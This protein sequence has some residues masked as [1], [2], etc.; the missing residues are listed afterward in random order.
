MACHIG[1]TD[2][3]KKTSTDRFTLI[4]NASRSAKFASADPSGQDSR[5]RGPSHAEHR[6]VHSQSRNDLILTGYMSDEVLAM[7]YNLCK[8]FV[9]PSYNEV[10]G[11]P[12]SE[13]M[14]W[15]TAV[16]AGNASSIPEIVER[17]DALIDPFSEVATTS[18][19]T[20]ALENDEFCEQL[21]RH[22]IHN[23]VIF[24]RDKC[25]NSRIAALEDV[26]ADRHQSLKTALWPHRRPKLAYISP[27][28]PER[29][30][31]SDYSTELL[32]ELARHYD[33]EVINAQPEVSDPWIRA[34]LPIRSVEYFA[35]N[36]DNFERVL[37]HFGNSAF[38]HYMFDLL[39]RFPGVVVLHDFFLGDAYEYLEHISP[40]SWTRELSNSH[41]YKAL[42][43]RFAK[44]DV[45]EVIFK[46]PCNF[47]VL[48]MAVGVIVHSNY[49]V[50]LANQWYGDSIARHFV[51]IP[52]L[53]DLAK[54]VDRDEARR[55]LGVH[56]DDFMVCSFG[57]LGPI[58]QNHRLLE[59]FLKS[60][61]SKDPGC[62]LIFIGENDAGEYGRE[63]LKTVSQSGLKER[64]LVTGWV[65]ADAFRNYLAAA[66][67]AVQLRTISRGES[68][69]AVLDCMSHALATIVN[70]NGSLAELPSDAVWKLSD[71]F[72]NDELIWALETLWRDPGRRLALGSR[73]REVIMT[74][75]SSSRCADMYEKA[76]EAFYDG[77]KSCRA[78]LIDDLARSDNLFTEEGSITALADSI[79]QCRSSRRSAPQILIDIS[80]LV[81]I[82]IKTGIQRVTRSILR[83][84][85]LNQP[86]GYRIEPVYVSPD[87]NG[88][89]YAREFCLHFLN[90]PAG[91][92]IDEPIDANLGDIFL[93]LDLHHEAIVS[94]ANY[95]ESLRNAGVRIFFI[96]Y[97]ILPIQIPDA[98]PLGTDDIHKRWLSSICR[99]S[100]GVMCIS[101]TVADDVAEWLN[102][103]GQ[104]RLRPL[105]IGWFHIGADI[106]NS[107][108]TQGLPDDA[109]QIL[110][111]LSARPSF[112]MVGTVEPRKG[113]LQAIAAFEQLWNNG[114]DA[115]LVIVGKEG[116]KDLPNDLRRTI[117]EIVNRLRHHPELDCRLF[118]LEGISDEYLEKIYIVSTCLIAA[119]EGEGFGLPLIEAAQHKLPI[120]ARDIPVFRE[121]AG[122]HAFYFSGKEPADLADSIRG[123]LAL[124]RSGKHPRSYGMAWL[125]WNE[126]AE[127]LL[128][129]ILNNRWYTEW[130]WNDDKKE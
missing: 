40:G 45:R 121:V 21:S 73:A 88:Y 47:S 61:M 9:F 123:W 18:K 127:R 120:I 81:Q 69:K 106:E 119:S 1:G 83:E 75:N 30:G 34:H 109:S 67:I 104:K 49:S 98:F 100:D 48:E 44:K 115:N 54:M 5:H 93:G 25:V 108:P 35:K 126:S 90:C 57:I 50:T 2:I 36:A 94:Q 82:D 24:S 113:Y 130:K 97:N 86:A 17:E 79:T 3:Q 60:E 68:S 22:S 46:Y 116:W 14:A 95:L 62:K 91:G 129:I 114:V 8:L 20:E 59:A 16:I 72:K 85:L 52:M 70:S 125:R 39:N 51:V 128:Y 6:Q 111:R 12:L 92:L 27:L 89:R 107:V 31:I 117:P 42:W 29:S 64:I 105:K 23:A 78:S 55:K 7:L 76:I 28:P 58:K 53:R 38:H 77:A 99:L 110:A 103:N 87:Q 56:I 19:I 10:F 74:E 101:Q 65:D 80:A 112:L 33:I 43:E 71:R 41:G 32:P 84:L 4:R 13:S 26:A 37:Y 124:C 102:T 11:L 96:V 63:F 118:W 15:A 66:D 122:N